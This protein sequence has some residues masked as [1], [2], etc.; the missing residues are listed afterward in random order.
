VSSADVERRRNGLAVIMAVEGSVPFAALQPLA[1]DPDPATSAKAQWL[2]VVHA[3]SYV[4]QVMGAPGGP[5]TED[6]RTLLRAITCGNYG[7]NVHWPGLQGLRAHSDGE[8]AARATLL[9]FVFSAYAGRY[10]RELA[11][12]ALRAAAVIETLTPGKRSMWMDPASFWQ[13]PEVADAIHEVLRDG[14]PSVRLAVVK[15]LSV[16]QTRVAA[17]PPLPKEPFW[18][19]LRVRLKE[20]LPGEPEGALKKEMTA[21]LNELERSSK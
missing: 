21:L 9:S 7:I 8:V 1:S 17:A 5:A 4:D 6:L 15:Q 19:Q 11:R 16:V 3:R 18:E 12:D 14:E 2:I 13:H 10:D 20:S